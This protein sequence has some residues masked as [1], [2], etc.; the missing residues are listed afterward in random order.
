MADISAKTVME[1]RNKMGVSMMACKKALVEADGDMEKAIDILRKSG[2][3]KADKKANRETGEGAAAVFG[4]AVLSLRCETDFV[5]RNEDFIDALNNLV[6]EAD[7]NGEESA[8]EMFESN[9]TDLITKLGENISFGEGKVLT[10]GDT[11]GGYLHSNRKIATLVSLSGGT[12]ELAKDI[13]MHVAA[14]APQVIS[15]EDVADEDVAKEKEIWAQQLKNEGKPENIIE[16]IM[17]GKEKKF[18]E[19]GA[20]LKQPFVKDPEVTIEK[21]LQDAGAQ[22]ESFVRITV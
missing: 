3:A 6:K 9:K 14:N 1:L 20:L 21:L 22:I 11:V 7:A 16:K 17:M 12:E 15:P 2:A 4:R 5:A 8:K 13:A 18:R 10:E 19:E